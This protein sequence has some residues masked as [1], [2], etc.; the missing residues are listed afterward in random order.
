MNQVMGQV[1]Y[2]QRG[3]ICRLKKWTAD[4]LRNWLLRKTT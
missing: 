4:L 3:S 2:Q 1:S